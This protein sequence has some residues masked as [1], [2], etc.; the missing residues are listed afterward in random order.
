MPIEVEEESDDEIK[1]GTAGHNLQAASVLG[2]GM[3]STN[4]TTTVS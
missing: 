3:A 2:G 1:W 4:A